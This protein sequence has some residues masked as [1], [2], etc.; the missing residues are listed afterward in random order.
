M[1]MKKT[2]SLFI[3]ALLLNVCIAIVPFSDEGKPLKAN[4]IMIP[5]GKT[6]RTISL[7]DFS[8]LSV[9]EYQKL[10]KVKL[11]F[12]DR[13]AYRKALK[14]LN[15]G[16]SADGTVTNPKIAQLMKPVVDGS[17]G[18]HLGG[19]ALGLLLG[20]AGVAIAYLI[21]GD[22]KS[23]RIKWAWIGFGVWVAIL[24]IGLLI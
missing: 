8:K 14:K 4:E 18:F 13:I 7:A 17:E 19:L 1:I 6:G 24:L 23:N 20:L 9:A 22:N 12:F 16:I 21:N 15:K 5:I 3:A 11:G 10:A 2:F